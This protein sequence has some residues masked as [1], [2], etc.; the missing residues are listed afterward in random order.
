M[1]KAF[2]GDGILRYCLGKIFLFE[3]RNPTQTREYVSHL[4]ANK[5]LHKIVLSNEKIF[6]KVSG[7]I[8]N[9][10]T[11]YEAKL[12]D[13]YEQSGMKGAMKF[14]KETYEINSDS[15]YEIYGNWM[16]KLV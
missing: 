12:F 8:H 11:I 1:N 13:I 9:H 14:V 10:G 6:G 16:S 2:C 3:R 7:T 15:P 4:T 5:I